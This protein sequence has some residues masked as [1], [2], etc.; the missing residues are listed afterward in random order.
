MKK[1]KFGGVCLAG[2]VM[3]AGAVFSGCELLKSSK[4]SSSSSV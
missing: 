2:L 1:Q 3:M 4:D